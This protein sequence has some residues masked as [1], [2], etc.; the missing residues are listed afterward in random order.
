VYAIKGLSFQYHENIE[1]YTI[2][3]YDSNDIHMCQ[4]YKETVPYSG[5][6]NYSQIQNDLDKTNFETNFKSLGNL[7]L[8][9]IDSD[10][11]QI[12]RVKAA[13]RGWSYSAIPI[14]LTTSSISGVFYSKMADGTDRQGITVKSYNSNLEEVT[15]TGEANINLASITRT[16]VDFEPPFDYE[17]IG[18]ALRT[19]TNIDV[20]MRLWIIAVPDVP[21]N[22]G[23]SKEMAS[24]INLR[25]LAPTNVYDVDGRVSKFLAYNATYHTNKLRFIFTYPAGTTETLNLTLELFK[26]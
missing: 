11:A 9:Q 6:P 25:Y 14:E 20:D 15:T 18:G 2:W 12:V 5:N 4:I 21:L 3:T 19:L 22:S 7:S 26:L 10:G 1:L 13:K 8:G 23:G 24:G 16:V 17:I